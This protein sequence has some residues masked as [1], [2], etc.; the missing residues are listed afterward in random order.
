[1][2]EARCPKADVC[3]N[4]PNTIEPG[5]IVAT[6]LGQILGLISRPQQVHMRCVVTVKAMHRRIDIQIGRVN[7]FQECLFCSFG[8]LLIIL[9]GM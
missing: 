6:A 1:M 3:Y 4:L 8:I 7:K 2:A 5:C 9:K